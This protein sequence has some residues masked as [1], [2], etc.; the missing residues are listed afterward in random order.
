MQFELRLFKV[1]M[2]GLQFY[3]AFLLAL[4]VVAA[5]T[6]TYNFPPYNN[7][8]DHADGCALPPPRRTP[9]LARRQSSHPVL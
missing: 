5:L 6:L 9:A 4:A 8:D 2:T 7:A 1:S 3:A